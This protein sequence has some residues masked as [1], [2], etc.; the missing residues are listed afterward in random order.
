[1]QITNAAGYIT[2]QAAS[3]STPVY[4]TGAKQAFSLATI[5][6]KMAF[7]GALY[8][9]TTFNFNVCRYCHWER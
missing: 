3:N 4:Q 8:F 9:N 6:P 7:S 2:V 5:K 1:M